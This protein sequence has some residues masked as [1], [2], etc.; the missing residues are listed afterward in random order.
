M[1]LARTVVIRDKIYCGGGETNDYDD[2]YG[3]FCYNSS[4]DTW[5]SLPGCPVWWFG[6]GQVRGKLVTVGGRTKFDHQITNKVY[7]FDEMTQSWKRNLRIPPMTTAR[8]SPAVL[9]H[10]AALVVAGGNTRHTRTTSVEVYQEKTSQWHT[11][12][13]LPFRWQDATS[14][15]INSRWYLLGGAA[16]GEECSNRVMCANIDLLLRD[17]NTDTENSKNSS[18]VWQILPNTLYY[19]PTAA[20]L[21]EVLLAV[22]GT[23]STNV[24]NPQAAV[25]VYSPHSNAWLHISDLPTPRM[26]AST[27]VLSSTELLLIGGCN[28]GSHL[29][30]VYKGILRTE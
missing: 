11:T 14:V 2:V 10:H 30:T 1:S 9:S 18:S 7:E 24:S 4:E 22:G 13:P 17:R 27:A 25:Y 6:L 8:D 5:S 28:K 15:L 3:V 26:Q 21:G 23:T 12:E 29:N 16:E 20:T 19:G